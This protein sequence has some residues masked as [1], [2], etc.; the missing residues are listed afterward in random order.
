M[1]EGWGQ[2]EKGE[3]Q[4]PWEPPPESWILF[5]YHGGLEGWA[6]PW[7]FQPRVGLGEAGWSWSGPQPSCQVWPVESLS[8]EPWGPP[9]VLSHSEHYSSGPQPFWHQGPVSWKTIFPWTGEG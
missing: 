1:E 3:P 6:S 8:P 9:R 5:P 4:K 2:V 7:A